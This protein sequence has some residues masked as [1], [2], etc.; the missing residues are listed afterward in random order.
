MTNKRTY[1]ASVLLVCAALCA[2]NDQPSAY[3]YRSTPVE[4]WELGDT[5]KFHVDSINTTGNYQFSLGL[6]TSVSTPYPYQSLW[7]VVKQHWHNPEKEVTDTIQCILTNERGDTQGHG[8][9]LYQYDQYIK[10][11]SLSKG[12]S[13]DISIYHIMRSE[14]IPGISDVGIKLMIID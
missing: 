12:M 10:S 2:C 7:L 11:L 5:L 1:A 3:D 14:M 4:G 6:R 13:A 9:S 8:V